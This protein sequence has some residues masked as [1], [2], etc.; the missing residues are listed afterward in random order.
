MGKYL[1]EWITN[2]VALIQYDIVPSLWQQK[3]LV[4]VEGCVCCYEDRTT[5]EN[6]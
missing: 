5:P 2:F 4:H 3:M 1:S 6:S